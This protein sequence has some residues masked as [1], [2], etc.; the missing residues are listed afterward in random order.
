MI[1]L[2]KLLVI[3]F[4]QCG[5]VVLIMCSFLWF[6]FWHCFMDSLEMKLNWRFPEFFFYFE[7]HTCDLFVEILGDKFLFQHVALWFW[8][9]IR[10][11]DFDM[12]FLHS[13]VQF[14]QK[15]ASPAWLVLIEF[16]LAITILILEK[17]V[18]EI[19]KLLACFSLCSRYYCS[20]LDISMSLAQDFMNI[21]HLGYCIAAVVSTSLEV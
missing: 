19:N 9:C 18:E 10:F 15:I 11:S 4:K 8:S 2:W 20:F 13:S 21:L 5:F 16:A 7:L 6:F 12:A 1:C 14:L 17:L 3:S